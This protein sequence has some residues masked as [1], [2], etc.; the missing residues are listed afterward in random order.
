LNYLPADP[1]G[2]SEIVTSLIREVLASM[3]RLVTFLGRAK[4]KI[5]PEPSCV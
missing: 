2:V 5:T 3:L 4:L 1:R